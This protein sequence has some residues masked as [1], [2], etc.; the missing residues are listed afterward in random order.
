[1][2]SFDYKKLPYKLLSEIQKKYTNVGWI[3][4]NHSAD[5]TEIAMFGPGSELHKPFIKNTDLHWFLLKV[6]E[7]AHK[8]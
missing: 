1:M 2:N 8:D 4:D 7:V 6:S 5:Y 3:G